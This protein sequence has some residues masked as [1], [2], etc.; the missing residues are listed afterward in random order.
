VVPRRAALALLSLLWTA[1][2]VVEVVGG[3]PHVRNGA[4]P[5]QGREREGSNGCRHE[6]PAGP[7]AYR[8]SAIARLTRPRAVSSVT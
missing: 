6:D 4:E 2:A 3:V 7:L 8:T 5:A 1:G